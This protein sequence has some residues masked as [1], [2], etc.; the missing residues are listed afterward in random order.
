MELLPNT[1]YISKLNEVYLQVHAEL[2]IIRELI[3]YFSF[4][5]PGF[6][7]MPAFKTGFWDGKIRLFDNKN[8]L[9]VGLLDELIGF[10]KT[11]EYTT[12]SS[13]ESEAQE[14]QFDPNSILSYL[15]SIPLSSRGED[16]T[17]RDYQLESVIH[18]LQTKRAILLAAT[19]SGKSSILYLLTRYYLDHF[20]DNIIL[21]VPTV[22]L[23]RQMYTDFE[24]YSEKNG[25]SVEDNVHQIYSGKEKNTNKRLTITTWQSI[26][27]MPKEWFDNFGM[28][29]VDECHSAA[30]KS[31]TG[32]LEKMTK[33]PY[34]IATTGTLQD[35]KCHLLTIQG[36][37][38]PVKKVITTKQLM[39]RNMA[40]QLKINCIML[41]YS[42]E[43]C[44]IAKNSADYQAEYDFLISHKPRNEF[45]ARLACKCPDNTLV[46]F[47]NE[48]HGKILY[49]LIKKRAGDR[50]VYFINGKINPEDR[51]KIRK[52]CET[53]IGSILVA[54][55]GTFS[56]GSNL[57]NIYDVI[58]GS[59][60]KSRIRNLQS[61]GRG[62]RPGDRG[63]LVRLHD[64]AD[65]LRYKQY[66]NFSLKHYL[67]RISLYAEQE[68]HFKELTVKI[69]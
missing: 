31:L 26:Y 49:D 6:R 17:A 43:I 36:L 41:E 52:L 30:A 19:A 56:V 33:T 60:T 25:W 65:N 18:C 66:M 38:G 10:A 4:E 24:D 53:E 23:V 5:V 46:L 45:I 40:S 13:L 42:E 48:E 47:K 57:R 58:F 32:I 35:T 39:D 69:K 14:P 50:K 62:L 61:I 16:I 20:E 22:G 1:I 51:E 64:I 28:V 3:E 21:I 29:M 27:K 7:Y 8:K 34:R 44:R 59:P 54:S 9:Y 12:I 11:Q 68:F 67:Y 55:Y 15:T 2:G 37:F 63:N